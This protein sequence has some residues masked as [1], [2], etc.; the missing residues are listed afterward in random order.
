[1]RD[2]LGVKVVTVPWSYF[3]R[4]PCCESC[5]SWGKLN[6]EIQPKL[7]LPKQIDHNFMND[8]NHHEAKDDDVDKKLFGWPKSESSL[9]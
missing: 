3:M 4:W 5:H 1:M 6:L 9:S 8:A 2:D 7:P